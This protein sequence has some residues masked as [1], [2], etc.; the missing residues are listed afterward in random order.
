MRTR[1]APEDK[2]QTVAF[3][4]SKKDLARLDE[5]VEERK[6]EAGY[7]TR[8]G[9]LEFIMLQYITQQEESRS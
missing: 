8:S 1:L 4:L 7:I 6:K 3:T 5:L 9:L 2:R